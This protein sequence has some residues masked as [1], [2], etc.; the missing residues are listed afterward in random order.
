MI[1]QGPSWPENQITGSMKVVIAEIRPVHSYLRDL[2]VLLGFSLLGSIV[3]PTGAT[4]ANTPLVPIISMFHHWD[5]HWYLWL[6]GDPVYEAVEVMAAE[7]APNTSPLVWVFFTERDG[8]K[9]QV[10]YLNDSRLAAATGAVSRD[11]AF[12]M[13]GAKGGPQ[14]VSVK[15]VDLQADRQLSMSTS[16]RTPGSSPTEPA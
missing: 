16:P 11:I 8:P 6:P 15:F 10:H 9:H 2:F 13:T 3:P 14:S 7:R 1:H 4:S 12:T 5:H